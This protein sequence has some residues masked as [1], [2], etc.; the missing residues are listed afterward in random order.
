MYLLNLVLKRHR[1]HLTNDLQVFTP[2]QRLTVLSGVELGSGVLTP[3]GD[4]AND[5]MQVSYMLQGVSVGEVEVTIYD[6][7]GRLV[8]RLV[9]ATRSEGRY[10]EQWDGLG[11]GG[12]AV[13]PGLYLVR[14]SVG[15]D[16]GTFEQIRTLAVV[17]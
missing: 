3:N 15:T 9:A 10:A 7:R 14:V 16:L 2:L 6:L 4:G 1:R 13:A 5:E 17:Y 8:R 12:D 11:E